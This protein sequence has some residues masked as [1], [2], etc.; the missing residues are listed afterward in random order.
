M[1]TQVLDM[2]RVGKALFVYVDFWNSETG[3]YNTGLLTFDTGATITTISKDILHNL[4][5]N[6][7]DG[8]VEKI[9]TASG[10][11][12]VREVIVNKIR[13]NELELE[14]VTVYAHTFPEDGFT[15]GVIGL[16]ILSLFDINMLFSKQIIELIPIN[17]T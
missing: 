10:T 5:Y 9:T 4:G 17:N 7:I 8:G 15:T 12:Y 11:E 14:N 1:G 16:D 13:L 3:K 6:V 2:H